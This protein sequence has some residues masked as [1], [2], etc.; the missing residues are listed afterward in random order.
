MENIEI[1]IV[2]NEYNEDGYFEY[3]SAFFE[4]KKAQEV[5]DKLNERNN[6]WTIEEVQV[7]K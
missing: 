2:V 1:Y 6:V 7:T 5:C 3:D 4:Y